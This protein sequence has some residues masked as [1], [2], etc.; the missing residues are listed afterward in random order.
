MTRTSRGEV[1]QLLLDWGKGDE[2][3]LQ[4]LVPLVKQGV[5]SPAASL[6]GP[7]EASCHS[8]EHGSGE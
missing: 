7:R 8:S 5:A 4:R 3:A 2:G 1:T 6:H